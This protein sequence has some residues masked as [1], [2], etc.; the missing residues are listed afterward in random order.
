MPVR[1]V[2]TGVEPYLGWISDRMTAKGAPLACA[3][4]SWP[5]SNLTLRRITKQVQPTWVE[6]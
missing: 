4:S 6:L 1:S 5:R 3:R 2:Y